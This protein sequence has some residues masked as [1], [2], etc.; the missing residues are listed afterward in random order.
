MASTE[1]Q[2]QAFEFLRDRFQSQEPFTRDEFRK[3]IGL[4]AHF[5]GEAAD[6]FDTLADGLA[7]PVRL[8]L[9]RYVD[10]LLDI[11]GF[12]LPEQFAGGRFGGNHSIRHW[13][14]SP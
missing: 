8:G 1:N 14:L 12:A 13:Y 7:S 10:S 6:Q 9:E 2:R 5:V 4:F 11:P 3:G